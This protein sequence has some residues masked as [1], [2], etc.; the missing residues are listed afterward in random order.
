MF[1]PSIQLLSFLEHCSTTIVSRTS[2]EA[3]QKGLHL[4]Q[5]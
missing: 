3:K 5:S 1:Q 4:G 2:I